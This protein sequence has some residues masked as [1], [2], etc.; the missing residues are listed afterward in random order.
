MNQ[1]LVI[2]IATVAAF[3]A[4]NLMAKKAD[5]TPAVILEAII[6][7]PDGNTARYFNTLVQVAV[8]EVPKLLAA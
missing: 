6:A 3:E 1:N 5:T 4:L 2:N 8:R 7:D